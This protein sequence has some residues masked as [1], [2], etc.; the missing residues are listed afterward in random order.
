MQKRSILGLSSVL[1]GVLWNLREARAAP[2][3]TAASEPVQLGKVRQIHDSLS[4]VLQHGNLRGEIMIEG[5]KLDGEMNSVLATHGRNATAM[6]LAIAD[7][8]VWWEDLKARATALSKLEATGAERGEAPTQ[9]A[10]DHRE[11]QAAELAPQLEAKA[12][13]ILSHLLAEHSKMNVEERVHVEDDLKAALGKSDVFERVLGMHQALVHAN[14][15]FQAETKLLTQEGAQLAREIEEQHVTVLYGMLKQRQRL[16][17][18]SQVALL[19][20]R[21]FANVTYAQQLLKKHGNS[22]SLFEQLDHLLSRDLVAKLHVT[23]A[24]AK[25]RLAAAGSDG[26]VHIV[27]SRM[28]ETVQGMIRI[29]SQAKAKLSGLVQHPSKTLSAHEVQEAKEI[30]AGLD[31]VLHDVTKTHD[32]KEQLDIMDVM[33]KRLGQWMATAAR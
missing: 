18:V 24:H 6:K 5:Q 3:P 27:S 28:K 17:M 8:G 20:R 23:A 7:F 33:Q 25:D 4:K 1:L 21:E 13:R 2:L 19:R 12:K 15:Y 14:K 26:R 9:G 32:L 30:V 22:T 31:K 11:E 16:P 10:E 29:M